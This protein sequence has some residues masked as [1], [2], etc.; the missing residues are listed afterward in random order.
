MLTGEE[1]CYTVSTPSWGS[2]S[3][4]VSG[5]SGLPRISRRPRSERRKR[6]G[7]RPASRRPLRTS[8]S[9][10]WPGRRC[11]RSWTRLLRSWP[12]HTTRRREFTV[13][14]V[15]CV[16]AVAHV[17][18]TAIDRARTEDALRKSEEHFRSL[19]DNAS[20]I[21]TILGEDGIFRYA[22]PSV[23]RLLGYAPSEL[24]ER[25][26]FEFVHADDLVVVADALGRAIQTPG[27]PQSA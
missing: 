19:I 2:W 1:Q 6:F 10:R 12:A 23:Q 13:Y 21:V 20:D 11:L 22:S 25:N 8:A 7:L 15:H 17:L 27:T 3:T 4:A 5:S 18:A 26:A 24:L 14:D 16:Q 9:R